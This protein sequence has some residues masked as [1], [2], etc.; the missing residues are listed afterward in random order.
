[1]NNVIRFCKIEDPCF[2]ISHI[3]EMCDALNII[4]YKNGRDPRDVEIGVTL[5]ELN[6]L[7]DALEAR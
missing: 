6:I 4:N 7:V 2:S 5:H 3:I 1:M